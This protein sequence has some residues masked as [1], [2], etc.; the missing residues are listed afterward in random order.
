MKIHSFRSPSLFAL[1][2]VLGVGSLSFAA[3]RNGAARAE[4]GQ[5]TG[6]IATQ[7]NLSDAQKSQLQPIL[8]AAKTQREA[9]QGNTTLTREQKRTQM[10]DL[11]NS[12]QSQIAA[13]L[14][15]AQRQQ[16]AALREQRRA[17]GRGNQRG[18]GRANGATRRGA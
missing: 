2:C 17:Q 9:L 4:R 1:T 14:T 8:R 12:T 18:E 13:I 6:R 7:L 16:L 15:P 11:R 5:R 3:P 10:R